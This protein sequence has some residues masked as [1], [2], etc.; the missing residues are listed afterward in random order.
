MPRH[1]SNRRRGHRIDTI[2][3]MACVCTCEG[4]GCR[5]MR[6]ARHRLGRAWESLHSSADTIVLSATDDEDNMVSWVNSNF[7]LFGSHHRAWLRFHAAQPRRPVLARPEEPERD[8]TAQASVQYALGR[9]RHEGRQSPD[10]DHTDGQ[11]Q[12]HA[13]VSAASSRLR[14]RRGSANRPICYP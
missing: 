9:V 13:Q 12:G 2:A 6:T 7:S 5:P 8:R 14:T 3:A 11:A 10:D 1:C 4:F